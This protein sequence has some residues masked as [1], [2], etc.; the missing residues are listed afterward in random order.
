MV[1]PA[2]AF[3][4]PLDLVEG[5]NWDASLGALEIDTIDKIRGEGDKWQDGFVDHWR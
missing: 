1:Q 3:H 5:S 4:I 2:K